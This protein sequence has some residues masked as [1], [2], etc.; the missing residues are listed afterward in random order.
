MAL[1][2]INRN[3]AMAYILKDGLR[4]LWDYKYPKAAAKYLAR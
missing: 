1:L 4:K 2:H 3:L